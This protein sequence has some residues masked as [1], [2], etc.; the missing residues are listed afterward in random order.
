MSE[1]TQ[2][3][4]E[5][6]LLAIRG[7]LVDVIRD[8]TTRPGMQHPLS[9]RTREEIC[10]CLDLITARQKEMAEAAGKP[11][12]ERPIYPEEPPCNKH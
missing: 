1:N 8:T 11:L 3:F 5:R 2:T 10:H 12:D 9:E 4:E 7:T 6:I